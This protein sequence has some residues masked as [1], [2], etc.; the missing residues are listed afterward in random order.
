MV[1]G[2][3]SR[4]L[5]NCPKF[6]I[7]HLPPVFVFVSSRWFRKVF[8]FDF[9]SMFMGCRKFWPPLM[10]KN[11]KK[12]CPKAMFD[13]SKE[14]SW[15]TECNAKKTQLFTKYGFW[16][17]SR[18]NF[19]RFFQK[20]YSEKSWVF[21]VAFSAS[22]RF[23]WA[24]KNSFWKICQI[25][26]HKDFGGY[27]IYGNPKTGSKIKKKNC[28]GI[29]TTKQTQKPVVKVWWEFWEVWQ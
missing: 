25:F 17:K 27:K 20:L 4:L 5:P 9:L 8:L 28:F 7:K 10:M 16:K 14:A 18:K 29:S 23:F 15:C 19:S 1:K 12:N 24:I 6:L 22:E 13:S 11:L 26:P 2:Q 3:P 21:C